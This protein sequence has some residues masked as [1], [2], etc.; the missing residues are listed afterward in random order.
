MQLRKFGFILLATIASLQLNAQQI[1]VIPEPTEVKMGYGLYQLPGQISISMPSSFEAIGKEMST[2]FKTATGKAVSLTNQKNATIRFD[3]VQD[4]RLGKEGYH[5]TVN[6]KGIQVKAQTYAGAL[7]AWQSILQLLP[8]AIFSNQNQQKISWTL[9]F[10][11]ITDTPRFEWRGFMMDVSR[12]FFTVAEVKKMM[13]EMTMYKLNRLHFHLTDDQGWRVEI[14]ALPKLTQVGAWRPNRIGKWHNITKPATEEP[15]TYGGFYTQEDIKELV[16]YAKTKHIEIMPEIDV[17]GHSMAFLAAYPQLS[18]TPNYPYQVNAGEEFIDWS[19]MNGHITARIDNNLDPSKKE[20]YEYLD[21]I[22]GELATLFPFEYIHMGGDETA[23]NNWAKSADIKALM[24]KENLKNQEEVQSYFVRKVEKIMQSKGK[25]LMGWDE[26]LE[27]GLA[28]D[29]AV[30]SWRGVKGG[31]EAAKQKHPVVM[32]PSSHNY[33]DYYQGEAT[34]EG[35]VYA[36]LRM[37]KTYSFEPV[38][39]GVE[40]KYILGNQG[41]LWSEQLQNIRNLEYMAWPRLMAIAEVAWSPKT[42]KDWNRFTNKV[43]S[44]FAILD[45][46]KIKYAKSI[47]DPIVTTTLNT[48]GEL[49]AHMEGEING[50]DFYY[51]IDES[52]PDN[53]SHH[54]NAPI[55]IPE[56]VTILRVMSYQNGKPIGKLLN[57]PLAALKQR[58]VKVL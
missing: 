40:E 9:P 54:F 3:Q 42:S 58:A 48:K 49:Y 39:E 1:K 28:P 38:P 23:K 30:M 35:A 56:D 2:R 4:N 44:H 46:L 37:K 13:D 41:N 15:K 14:K 17:P 21:I 50:L 45:T 16:A 7:Y 12:H 55:L 51:S 27:G 33:L 53:Y 36:G 34:A 19:G 6:E 24:Q 10:V 52:M 8:P 25:K 29:A 57:I 11:E 22:F 47:Y 5:L 20:V 31:A 18:T 43:E 32:S 26:I